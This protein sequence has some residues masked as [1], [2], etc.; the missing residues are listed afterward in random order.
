MCPKHPTKQKR[1][2]MVPVMYIWT[3]EPKGKQDP[4]RT[5]F[6]VKWCRCPGL[7]FGPGD[8]DPLRTTL[9]LMLLKNRGH[10]RPPSGWCCCTDSQNTEPSVIHSVSSAG[11]WLILWLHTG[12][13][14][15]YPHAVCCGWKNRS[16]LWFTLECQLCVEFMENF[17]Q[18]VF[19]LNIWKQILFIKRKRGPKTQIKVGTSGL[20]KWYSE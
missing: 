7:K 18:Q 10:R 6:W 3:E 19:L 9:A 17:L 13:Y 4:M 20:E 16:K 5:H 11:S 12:S 14:S 15:K 8:S 2:R 1:F